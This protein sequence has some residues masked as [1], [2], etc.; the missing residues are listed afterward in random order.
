MRKPFVQKEDHEL[1]MDYIAGNEDSFAELMH[2]HQNRIFTTI[3]LMVRD[4]ELAEDIFQETMLKVIRLMQNGHYDEK[5]KFVPWVLRIAKNYA[6]DQ[7]RREKRNPQLVHETDG[8]D[9]FGG[10]KSTQDNIEEQIIREENT[11][12]V[13]AL[14]QQIPENQREVLVMRHY[15]GMSFK[16]IADVQGINVNTALGRMRYA[17]MNLRRCAGLDPM[18]NKTHGTEILE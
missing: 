14:M 10:V 11:L 16:E 18:I 12:F 1:A 13:Q 2:R 9:L 8:V 5:G 3:Q 6:I 7:Y 15:G 17:L 4:Q